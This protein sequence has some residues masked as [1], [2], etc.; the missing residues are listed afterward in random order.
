[1]V[2]VEQRCLYPISSDQ[3]SA[4]SSRILIL[5]DPQDSYKYERPSDSPGASVSLQFVFAPDEVETELNAGSYDLILWRVRKTP[6]D[7]EELCRFLNR[8]HSHPPVV[9]VV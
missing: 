1:M 6:D 8:T 2:L 4:A 3:P 7:F 5:A 9:A